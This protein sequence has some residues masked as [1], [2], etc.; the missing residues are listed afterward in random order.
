LAASAPRSDGN[1]PPAS[2][3]HRLGLNPGKPG[4]SVRPEI[5]DGDEKNVRAQVDKNEQ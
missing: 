4:R 3:I 5:S 2:K 1:A